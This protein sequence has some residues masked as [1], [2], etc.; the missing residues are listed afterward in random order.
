[1]EIN[2]IRINNPHSYLNS[3]KATEKDLFRNANYGK[4]TDYYLKNDLIML[5]LYLESCIATYD[6]EYNI[7]AIDI[8]NKV[9][10]EYVDEIAYNERMISTVARQFLKTN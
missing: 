10:N 6:F 8:K 1:M 4:A 5:K 2:T 7:D 9:I 3:F